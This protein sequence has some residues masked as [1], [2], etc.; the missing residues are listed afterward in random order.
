[1]KRNRP[2]LSVF[3]SC[4]VYSLVLSLVN[5]VSVSFTLLSLETLELEYD[6]M[7]RTSVDFAR[8]VLAL[9][10]NHDSSLLLFSIFTSV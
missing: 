6:P 4:A 2:H 5:H 7:L 3:S 10:F 8:A 9:Y 1:M